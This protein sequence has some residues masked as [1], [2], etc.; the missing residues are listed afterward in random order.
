MRTL[1]VYLIATLSATACLIG[2]YPGQATPAEQCDAGNVLAC[3]KLAIETMGQCASPG[4]IGG[5]QFDSRSYR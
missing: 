3:R 1:S 4:G 5:C 2:Q